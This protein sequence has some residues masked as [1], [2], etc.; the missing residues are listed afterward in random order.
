MAE[1][2]QNLIGKR[3]KG[4][5]LTLNMSFKNGQIVPKNTFVQI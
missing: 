4:T 3:R 5:S 1:S 2:T